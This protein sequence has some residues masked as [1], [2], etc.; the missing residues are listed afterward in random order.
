MGKLSKL[1]AVGMNEFLLLI[2]LELRQCEVMP[3]GTDR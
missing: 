3:T 1:I 2:T